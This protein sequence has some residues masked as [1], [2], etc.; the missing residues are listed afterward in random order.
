MKVSE[1]KKYTEALARYATTREKANGPESLIGVQKRGDVLK[2]ISGNSRAAMVVTVDEHKSDEG[3]YSFTIPARKFLQT[4]KVL[5]AR[6]EIEIRTSKNGISL[7]AQG[8][9]NID[10]ARGDLS[11]REAGFARKPKSFR[12][13]GQID[14]KNLKRMSKLFKNISAKVEVPS[15]QIV[16]GTGYA[17]AVA[18]GNRPMYANYRF[19][20]TSSNGPDDEYNMAGY[21][22]FWEG[23]THFSEDAVIKW[24]R[25]GILVKSAYAECYSAPYLVSRWDAEK[26]KADP[27]EEQV[28]WPIMVAIE[29]SDVA[30][31]IER[32][33]LTEAVKGQSAFDLEESRITLEVNTDSVRVM[34]Y[35]SSDGMD[36]Q[37]KATGKGIRSVR[38]DY[39]LTLLNAMDSKE[40][41]L[42][43][44]GGVPA[45]SIS[46]EDYSSW[47]ILLAPV[48][49]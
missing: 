40:V 21:R 7:H 48:A 47:T 46:A 1:F 26:Q 4:A 43:W 15:V 38:S 36:L 41:T 42:R 22:D 35:G 18:P 16:K 34:P 24:G 8:G 28:A 6:A 3:D 2:L 33:T 44:S 31:T 10:V 39:L 49:L 11:L 20:A 25:D 45:I 32:K 5:P 9:G 14:A 29:Q 19:P 17:T 12:A 30:F 23:L 13:E 37:C 27:P